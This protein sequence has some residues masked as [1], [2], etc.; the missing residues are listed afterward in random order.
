MIP[1]K[2]NTPAPCNPISSNCVVWQGPDIACINICNGDTVSDVVAALATKLCDIIDQACT[3]DPDLTGLDL[4]CALPDSGIPADLTG[5]LQA[6]VDYICNQATKDIVLPVINLP[7]CL[8]YNDKLGNPVTELPLEDWAD[9]ISNRICD[10]LFSISLIEQNILNL[11]DRVSILEDCVLPCRKPEVSDFDVVSSCIFIGQSVP[12]STLVLALETQFCSFRNAVGSVALVNAAIGAQCITGS[13]ESLTTR[14]PFSGLTGWVANPGTLAESNINQWIAICDL[15]SAVSDIQENCCDSG[16]DGVDFIFAW[17][18][19]DTTGNGVFDLINLNFQGST[20]PSGFSDCGG[21]TV[22]TITDADGSSVSQNIVV[23]NLINSPSGVNVDVTTLNRF[24]SLSIVVNFCIT[25]G[26]SQCKD[27]Q[28]LIAPMSAPCP[29]NIVVTPGSSLITVGFTNNLG[30][31]VTYEITATSQSTGV[32]LG[33]TTI[34][35]P[36]SSINYIFSGAAPGQ[37]Y[38]VQVSVIVNSIPK[39]CP[40]I[41]VTIPGETCA[42]VLT[43]VFTSDV[44]ESTDVYLGKYAVGSVYSR[45][46][47]D[48]IDEIIK[49]ESL[50]PAGPAC[51]S[52]T[53]TSPTMDYLGVAGDVA[54]TVA[55]E[56]ASPVSAEI[57]FS[58]DGITYGAPTSG[59]D[60]LRTISTGATSGSVYIKVDQTCTGPI[61]S[62]PTILRYDFATQV[63]STTQSPEECLSTSMS[64]AC[65]AGQEVARQILECG[66]NSYFVFGGNSDSYWFYV[67]KRVVGTITRYIYAGWDN[68]TQS[69]RSVVECCACPSYILPESIQVLCGN[70][71]DSVVINLPYVL[72]SGEPSMTVLSSPVLGNVTQSPTTENQ[73]TYTTVAPGS[74]DYADT[75]QIQLQPTIAGSGGCE[76][77]VITVQVAL[78]NCNVKLSYTD[79]DV[80]AFINTNGYTDA[81]GAKIKQ[82]LAELRTYWISE[83][84]YAGNIYFIPTDDEKWLG[85]HKAIVDNGSSWT[86]SASLPWQGLEVLPTS[87]SGGAGVFKSAAYAIIFSN[88]SDTEYHANTLGAGFSTQPT[89]EYKEDAA[90]LI[91]MTTGTTGTP[92]APTSTWGIANG[93]DINQFPLGL[94]TVLFPLTIHNSGGADAATILQMLAAYTAELIPSSKYGIQTAVDITSF[95]L[96]GLAPAMPYTAATIPGG[97]TMPQLYKGDSRGALALL[98]QEKSS[99]E[100]DSIEDGTN[101]KFKENLTRSVKGCNNTYPASTIPVTNTYEVSSCSKSETYFVF[102]TDHGCGT[103]AIGTVVEL[104]N[105]GPDWSPGTVDDWRSATSKCVTIID[106]CS[107]TAADVTPCSLDATYVDCVTCL[108]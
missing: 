41:A 8:Q 58:T 7:A 104:T 6:I 30:A 38:D 94:T 72:G 105:N 99:A 5:T 49:L 55:Y 73:F 14:Q 91:D 71:G 19:I 27:R 3:C 87:W 86:Q 69:V 103:I 89:P 39:L 31:T 75:F 107:A 85:Y 34:T 21:S 43:N 79:Q 48:P 12:I 44:V 64:T 29:Q 102:I 26:T 37:T 70:N 53:L 66:P 101:D 51:K 36:P 17:N 2:N 42:D 32:V 23:S 81:E 106:N 57:S 80:Y 16:C 1:S 77:A 84:G 20:I 63:W 52:A 82:G 60:G 50:G 28:L 88:Q 98:D 22:V 68:T 45:Y 56:D 76:V 4:K 11:A 25:D 93:I 74:N 10:I 90:A 46:W 47:Y 65:P 97:A 108:P 59:S 67:G 40:S 33:T 15:Y 83:F 100:L 61:T 78:V 24:Q 18:G 95:M 54:V 62:V 96:D 92:V 13:Q 9:L 35:N